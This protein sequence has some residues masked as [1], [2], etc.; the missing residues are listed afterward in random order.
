MHRSPSRSPRARDRLAAALAVLVPA[1]FA[2]AH[3]PAPEPDATTLWGY[4]RLVP[5]AGSQT[6]GGGYGDRRV[7]NVKRVDYS[8]LKFGV[9]FAPDAGGAVAAP[10][11][12]VVRDG[13]RGALLE[14]RYASTSP[15]AGLLITNATRA[16][17][18]VSVPGAARLERIAPGAAA[19]I[20][21][22]PVGETP[23]HLLGVAAKDAPEPTQVWVSDGPTA[24]VDASGRYVLRGL[25]PGPHPIRAWHPRLPPSPPHTVELSRGGVVRLDLEIGLDALADTLPAERDEARDP[26][27][28]PHPDGDHGAPR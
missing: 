8:Q 19:L 3:A 15:A 13:S 14:P 20:R 21:D 24:R 23:V 6:G 12:L 9:V 11:E 16:P 27:H 7:A 18:I 5:K 17:Q 22:L 10:A 25:V 4:V 28:D 26:S 1:A 2:C